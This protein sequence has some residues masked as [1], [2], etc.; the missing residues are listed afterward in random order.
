MVFSQNQWKDILSTQSFTYNKNKDVQWNLNQ[1]YNNGLD[2][3]LYHHS[4]WTSQALTFV[5][6]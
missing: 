4:E 3:E 2:F 5:G 1:N 6:M